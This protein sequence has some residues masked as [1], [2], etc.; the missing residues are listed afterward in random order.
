MD[1]DQ[2]IKLNENLTTIKNTL[3]NIKTSIETIAVNT[4]PAE[5]SQNSDEN[6]GET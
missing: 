2:A 3:A 6:T 1:R 4:T 5:D